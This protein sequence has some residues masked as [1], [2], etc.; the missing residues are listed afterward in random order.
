P[1]PIIRVEDAYGNLRSSD[2]ATVVSATRSAGSGTLQGSTN[3]TAVNGIVTF[4][5]LSH[6][7]ATNN[8][9]SFG[10]GALTGATSDPVAV[11]A[12]LANRL[13][14]SVQPGSATAGV[15]LGIQPMI[16]TQDQFG[17][18]SQGGLGSNVVATVSLSSGSG[19]LL[20]TTTVD[21]GTHAGNGAG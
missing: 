18:D 9:I 7:G 1:Q 10:S 19:P 4:T 11:S 20:G 17:N 5:N 3:V 21:I 2:S 14:F 15:P 8:T 16:K 12:G 6:L 13:A